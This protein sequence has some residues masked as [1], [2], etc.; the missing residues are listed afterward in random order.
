M[1]IPLKSLVV[2]HTARYLFDNFGFCNV[3]VD[4]ICK[5]A[6]IS[7]MSFYKYYN[8]KEKLIE[9]CLFFNCESLKNE[10]STLIES[11]SSSTF[12]KVLEKI[13]FLHVNLDSNYHLIFKA[14]F[15]IRILYPEAFK[16][17][18]VYR[19][20]L[21]N[22]IIKFLSGI[23]DSSPIEAANLLLYIIDGAIIQLLESNNF[24]DLELLWNIFS[25][26]YCISI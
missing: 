9:S 15:E 11:Y 7:K 4:R 22:L 19:S 18:M 6:N 8:S 16:V 23:I 3:G 21:I 1:E 10:V 2:L 24:S 26:N 13:F 17:V 14:I 25:N 20:W 12:L 5:E